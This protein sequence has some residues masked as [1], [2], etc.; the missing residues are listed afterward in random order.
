MIWIPLYGRKGGLARF[1]RLVIPAD[2][3][4]FGNP[5][6]EVSVLAFCKDGA[7]PHHPLAVLG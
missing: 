3:F 1:F 2:C 5:R 4:V 6:I 7:K